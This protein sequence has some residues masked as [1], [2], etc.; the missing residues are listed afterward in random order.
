VWPVAADLDL[1]MSKVDR[2]KADAADHIMAGYSL[3]ELV[4][5]ADPLLAT[6]RT[7][8]WLEN[9]V[10]PPLEWVIPDLVPEGFTLLVGSTLPEGPYPRY[11][12]IGDQVLGD[13]PLARVIGA[14]V[15]RRSLMHPSGDRQQIQPGAAEHPLVTVD[16][17]PHGG[18]S[19]LRRAVKSTAPQTPNRSLRVTATLQHSGCTG[20]PMHI[21]V[22]WARSCSSSDSH[23]WPVS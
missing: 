11:D 14:A 1:K 18:V 16:H 20:Q 7:F 21:R 6:V 4:P 2:E 17:R 23:M 12:G 15:R 22:A 19:I 13:R 10:L 9:Q 5:Y 3:A 8:D